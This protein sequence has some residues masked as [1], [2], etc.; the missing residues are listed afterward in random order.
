M[1]L[2]NELQGI[3]AEKNFARAFLRPDQRNPQLSVETMREGR[4]V[5]GAS[6]SLFLIICK[7][8]RACDRTHLRRL[9]YVDDRVTP[10]SQSG[11]GHD[12]SNAIAG[13]TKA[14]PTGAACLM[15][16]RAEAG[17]KGSLERMAT[18]DSRSHRIDS[19]RRKSARCR[20]QTRR[21]VV[22]RANAH[23]RHRRAVRD[24]RLRR[25]VRRRPRSPTSS[26]A[27][28]DRCGHRRGRRS[29]SE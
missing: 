11:V 12:G 15:T 13:F 7:K 25:D 9:R 14:V 18:L 29:C 24:P 17:E 16:S 20:G 2:F 3:F 1:S 8:L 4:I 28:R 23:C 22:S 19:L 10:G 6:L 21:I 27:W 26:P 5:H